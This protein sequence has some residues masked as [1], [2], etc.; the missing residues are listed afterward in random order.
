MLPIQEWMAK[1]AYFRRP[2]L[3]PDPP[4]VPDAAHEVTGERNF[5]DIYD[6]H[7]RMVWRTLRRLGVPES[8]ITDLT[9]KVFLTAYL[10]LPEFKDRA[11]LSTWL[12]E[13]CRR[14]ASGH[15]RSA[16]VR[17]EIA[18]DALNVGALAERLGTVGSE[19]EFARQTVESIL[20]KLSEAQRVVFTLF[21]LDEIDGPE[22]ASYLNIPLGTV[23]SRLRRARAAFRREVRKLAISTHL[24]VSARSTSVRVSYPRAEHSER[25]AACSG[26]RSG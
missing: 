11:L 24:G 16:A 13:I 5:R 10:K 17:Y 21:E 4:A 1:S 2:P 3:A 26:A 7:F 18:T 12:W 20:S 9:Q 14:V 6:S 19:G 25:G 15:R 23:R 22:I 8:D